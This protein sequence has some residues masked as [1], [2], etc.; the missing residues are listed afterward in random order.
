MRLSLKEL[1]GRAI[2]ATLF[3]PVTLGKAIEQLGFVQVDPIRCPVPA[4]DLILRHRVKGYRAG[5]IERQYSRLGIEE[6]RLYAFGFMPRSTWQLLHPRREGKLS[7]IEKQVLALAVA[8]KRVHPNDLEI[9]FGRKTV[10]NAWGGQSRE[11]TRALQSLHLRGLLR[12]A[13]RERG[14]H[15]YER[16][17]NIAGTDPAERLRQLVM[18]V[19]SVLA[20]LS[21]KSL[22]ITLGYVAYRAPALKELRLAVP[23]LVDSGDRASALIDGV[24]YLWPAKR[25]VPKMVK[26]GVRFL[27]SFDPLVWDRQRFE[28][29]WGWPYRFEAYVPAAKRQFG[30]YAMPMLW[31]EDIIGW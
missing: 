30:Y 12:V 7:S 10:E 27:A 25:R 2:A 26:S 6:G 18:A 21:D 19:A 4:Q 5:D 20:P 29:L 15:I 17:E 13:G 31:R 16:I 23:Q 9:H 28:H 11:S 24:R 3:P 14:V 8:N 22:A 1:R